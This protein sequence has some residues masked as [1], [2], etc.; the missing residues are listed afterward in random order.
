M[1]IDGKKIAEAIL[2]KTKKE[3]NCLKI[4]PVLAVILISNNPASL[5]FIKQKS[6]ACLNTEI[7][8]K[9]YRFSEKIGENELISEIEKICADKKNR[10]VIVQ[11][12]LPKKFDTEKI[13]NLIPPK[14]DVDALNKK[15]SKILSP[16]VETIKEILKIAKINP[17][18]KNVVVVGNG[19]L[20]GM[21]AIKWF[22]NQK[23][24]VTILDEYSKDITLP[25]KQADIVV[26]GVGKAGLI[27]SAMIKSGA[28]CIDFGFSKKDK[29]ISGDFRQDVAKKARI[30]T[31][32]P[33]GTGPITV[34]MLIVNLLSLSER[35]G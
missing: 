15:T 4:K 34:A 24:I 33:G 26:S 11:L 27:T 31:P 14:K 2:A 13:L 7:G 8:F 6:N 25:I 5:S 9:L 3:F 12:P 18:S 28:I 10:G 20:V 22:K 35:Q 30:F 21:P 32:T 17:K 16:I 19:R 29:K 1:I 23:A